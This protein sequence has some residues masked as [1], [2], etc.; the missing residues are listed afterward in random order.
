MSQPGPSLFGSPFRHEKYARRDPQRS[1]RR[2]GRVLCAAWALEF[3]NGH[4]HERR[5]FLLRDGKRP[6]FAAGQTAAMCPIPGVVGRCGCAGVY[7]LAF[8]IRRHYDRVA[9]TREPA[10]GVL[11]GV[12]CH[13]ARRGGRL[14]LRVMAILLALLGTIAVTAAKTGGWIV[15]PRTGCRAWN[16]YPRAERTS[17]VLKA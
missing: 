12:L 2:C 5:Q 4:R 3:K 6:S 13:L 14:M 9:S 15:D 1:R 16:N 11:A 8:L 7:Q 17:A 10:N